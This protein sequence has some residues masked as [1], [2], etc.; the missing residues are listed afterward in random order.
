MRSSIASTL[1]IILTPSSVWLRDASS[2]FTPAPRRSTHVSFRTNPFDVSTVWTANL[3]CFASVP[4]KR[5]LRPAPT[6]HRPPTSS[7]GQDLLV[8]TAKPIPNVMFL[9]LQHVSYRCISIFVSARKLTA[10][11]GQTGR[12]D[13]KWN[14]F[15]HANSFK[16]LRSSKVH[17]PLNTLR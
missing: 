16:V 5:D 10:I 11:S 12:P 17:I 8:S 7:R 13:L 1:G 6:S 4:I 14:R 9:I 15:S 2:I 3:T